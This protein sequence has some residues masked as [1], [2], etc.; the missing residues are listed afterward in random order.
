MKKLHPDISIRTGEA[1][2][3]IKPYIVLFFWIIVATTMKFARF[4]KIIPVENK[5]IYK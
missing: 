3:Y 4:R 2:G 5:F 1:V